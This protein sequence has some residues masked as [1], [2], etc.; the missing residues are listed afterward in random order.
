[1]ESQA[2][3]I[4]ITDPNKVNSTEQTTPWIILVIDDVQSVLDVTCNV[5][6]HLQFN[7]RRVHIEC[8]RS[9]EEARQLYL[10]YP[11]PAVILVDCVMETD[12]AG[13]DFIEYVRNEHNDHTT[14]IVLRTGQPGIAPEQEILESHHINDYLAKTELSSA[15]LR[16]RIITYLR[17]AQTFNTLSSQLKNLQSK[18]YNEDNYTLAGT[19]ASE[20]KKPLIQINQN[21]KKIRSELPDLLLPEHDVT[22]LDALYRNLDN[23]QYAV[24]YGEQI[25]DFMLEEVHKKTGNSDSLIYLSVQQ[26][27]QQ[28][29]N[30]YIRENPE[31]MGRIN[32]EKTYDFLLCVNEARYSKMLSRL[33]AHAFENVSEHP[34][35]AIEISMQA[36]TNFHKVSIKSNGPGLSQRQQ[37]QL[38]DPDIIYDTENENELGLTYCKRSMTLF[39]G[40]INY[41]S[42]N[43]GF[44]EF[45]LS[46]PVVIPTADE[47][48]EFKFIPQARLFSGSI[49][50]GKTILVIAD[51]TDAISKLLKGL[52]INIVKASDRKQ[53]LT[54]IEQTHCDMIITSLDM[55]V[56]DRLEFVRTARLADNKQDNILA[57][58]QAVPIIAILDEPNSALA[59][60]CYQ[61]GINAL[62]FVPIEKNSLVNTLVQ[63]LSFDKLGPH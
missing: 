53:A 57:K 37:E 20:I 17:N 43:A 16:S 27:T 10:R 58:N 46:F 8:A 63:Q 60:A 62:S 41:Y 21:L 61:S 35:L 42:S 54:A 9:G 51:E 23:S 4:T 36:D 14:Q 26:L 31:T 45:S 48:N 59:K 32:V 47:S 29:I 1:M 5:L 39:N 12:T 38:F 33:F 7:G 28:A 52:G 15:K 50:V 6:K 13:L 25:V 55:P 22:S 19:V 40:T 44:T 30:N 56:V 11:N 18:K 34:A 3:T 49:L 2:R 24:K